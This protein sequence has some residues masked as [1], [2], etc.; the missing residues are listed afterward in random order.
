MTVDLVEGHPRIE[1][2]RN[3]VAIK[4]GPLVYCIETP[5]LPKGASTLDVH[6]PCDA[7]LSVEHKPEFLGGVSVINAQVLLRPD[8]GQGMYRKVTRPAWQAY[9]TTFVPYFAWSNRGTAEMTVFVPV[10]WS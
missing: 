9:D 2:V 4:R 10:I 3:Q 6:L 1:E 8:E 7:E 5:D